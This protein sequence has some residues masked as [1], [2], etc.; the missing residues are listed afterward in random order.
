MLIDC[1]Y[2]RKLIVISMQHEHSRFQKQKFQ[3]FIENI[4]RQII[5]FLT[6][7]GIVAIHI[8]ALL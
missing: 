1:S 8:T 5:S 7:L 6:F 2:F 3:T 4:C